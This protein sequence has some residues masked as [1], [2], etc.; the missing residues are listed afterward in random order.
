MGPSAAPTCSIT[1]PVLDLAK[2]TRDQTVA[3]VRLTMEH[4][5]G[6]NPYR[7]RVMVLP[8]QRK[9]RYPSLSCQ[10]GKRRI[11]NFNGSF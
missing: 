1:D 9:V 11:V 4:F 7:D 2:L 5:R 6:R 3:L 10:T 8:S